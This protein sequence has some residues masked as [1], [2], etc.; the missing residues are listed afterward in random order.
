[1]D[2]CRSRFWRFL[3]M[4]ARRHLR[5]LSCLAAELPICSS[6]AATAGQSKIRTI[7]PSLESLDVFDSY[8]SFVSRL[9]LPSVADW[10]NVSRFLCLNCNNLRHLNVYLVDSMHPLQLT[11]KLASLTT[12]RLSAEYDFPQ[13]DLSFLTQMPALE[14]VDVRLSVKATVFF[15]LL[16][17][18]SHLKH[19]RLE[20]LSDFR[21]EKK[22]EVEESILSFLSEAKSLTHFALFAH[23][24][25]SGMNVRQL[26]ADEC[27]ACGPRVWEALT[28]LAKSEEGRRLTTAVICTRSA[29]RQRK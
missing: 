14:S 29:V 3:S 19:M 9:R 12:L 23:T 24:C 22:E 15:G 26:P 18:L 7:F 2:N 10:N 1:M 8:A 27:R 4:D 17:R 11:R 5:R 28:S 21:Y 20:P 25:R 16:I 13:V 6:G